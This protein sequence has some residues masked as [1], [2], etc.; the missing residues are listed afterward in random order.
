MKILLDMNLSLRRQATCSTAGIESVHWCEVGDPCALDT[1][2]ASYAESNG[3]IVMT[4]DLDFGV[5]LAAS[6]D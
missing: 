5:L 3:L 2:L 1:L 6:G 4:Q